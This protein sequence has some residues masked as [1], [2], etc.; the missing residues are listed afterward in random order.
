MDFGLSY[1][2][3]LKSFGR[4]VPGRVFFF[5]QPDTFLIAEVT[6]PTSA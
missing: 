5:T 1:A 3:E 4:T 2:S 6:K